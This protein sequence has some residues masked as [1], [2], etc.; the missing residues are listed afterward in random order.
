MNRSQ[1]RA[2]PASGANP[3]KNPLP[4]EGHRLFLK[5]VAH[6]QAKHFSQAEEL[7]TQILHQF[8]HHADTLHLRGLLAYQSGQNALALAYIEQAIT[9]DPH[10]PHYYYNLGLVREKEER[11]EGAIAAYQQAMKANPNYIE[12]LTNLGNV[13]RRQ[14]QWADA[15]TTLQHALHLNPQSADISNMLGVTFKEKGDLEVA[16]EYYQ[17]ALKVSPHH[18]E[19][20][21]NSGVIFQAQGK[22]ANAADAFQQALTLKPGYANAHY[23]L[24]LVY[25]W[26]GKIPEALACF[27]HSA[28]LTSNHGHGLAPLFVTK[29]RVK[30][31]YEQLQHVTARVPDLP[32]PPDYHQAL[33]TTFHH[34]S[35]SSSD[36]LFLKLTPQERISLAPSFNRLL[37]VRPTPRLNK[38]ALNPHLDVPAIETRYFSTTPEAIHVDALLTEKALTDLRTFAWNPR[39]GNVII[40]TGT[41]ERFWRMALPV[42]CSCKWPKNSGPYFPQFSNTTNCNKLGHSNRTAPCEG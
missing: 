19:A 11:W 42:P 9:E 6:H 32:I 38:Q 35:R 34:L 18:A 36:S 27:Q 24:G 21:N 28:D 7:Y 25:L 39:S 5:A 23:H 14:R 37:Y 22:L 16:L 26:Q 2:G 20:L 8:P 41:S 17:Q 4:P 30:H 10:K 3:G 12:A 31:D 29:A 13:Y 40:Q 33:E 15:I 1:R